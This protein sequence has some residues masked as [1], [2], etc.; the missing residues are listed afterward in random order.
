MSDET[1]KTLTQLANELNVSR[2]RII[3]RYKKLPEED[4]FKENN[5]IYL[6]NSGIQKIIDD[7]GDDIKEDKEDTEETQVNPSFDYLV[8]QLNKKDEQIDQL[9]KLV[10]Q[11]Q[12]LNA[13]D[14]KL[15]KEMHQ[16]LSLEAPK[17]ENT[18]EK[19]ALDEK[20]QQKDEQ[21]TQLQEKVQQTEALHQEKEAL[22]TELAS[23]K[24]KNK[25]WYQF[26][27]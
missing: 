21:L 12:Q 17:E 25:K 16:Y 11:Q 10:D 8:E 6:L 20:L 27:K 14:K 2:D 26:W 5:T 23:L 24:Q 19:E 1:G 18:T 9:H 7:L 22:E 13:E 4:Y 3:Y 15:I